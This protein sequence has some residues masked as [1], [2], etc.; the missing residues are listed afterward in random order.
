MKQYCNYTTG[1][2]KWMHLLD[3]DEENC[4][5]IILQPETKRPIH[6]PP[7]SVY[8]KPISIL[9]FKKKKQNWKQNEL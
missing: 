4:M 8:L 3:R 5:A 1:I 7:M 9:L 2:L 6:K